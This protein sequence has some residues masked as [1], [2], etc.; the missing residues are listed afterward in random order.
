MKNAFFWDVTPCGF[1]WNRQLILPRSV[2]QLPVI[3]YV[4]LSSLIFITL[5]EAIRSSETPI[6]TRATR[7]HIPEDGILHSHCR[8]NFKSYL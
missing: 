6:L 1:C 3:T 2:L 4:V 7:R 5:M 8:G